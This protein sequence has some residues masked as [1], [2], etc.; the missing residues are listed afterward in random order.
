MHKSFCSFFLFFFK[1]MCLFCLSL[2]DLSSLTQL[3]RSQALNELLATSDI[4]SA[5]VKTPQSALHSKN[6]MAAEQI[7]KNDPTPTTTYVT[8]QGAK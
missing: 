3:R 5:A 6:D 8:T 4:S 7:I 2:E 1:R